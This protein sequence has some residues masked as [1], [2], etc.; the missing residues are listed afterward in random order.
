MWSKTIAQL[1]KQIYI[2]EGMSP[3]TFEEYQ[4]V[5]KS[6]YKNVLAHAESPKLIIDFCKKTNKEDYIRYGA[7]G[8]QFVGFFTLGEIVGRRSI[9]GYKVKC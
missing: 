1:A 4:A 6:L 3:P 8:L 5:Y 7:Y 2:K 9:F